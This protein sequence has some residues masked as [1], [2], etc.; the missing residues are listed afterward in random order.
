MFDGV[1]DARHRLEG[2]ASLARFGRQRLHHAAR[3]IAAGLRLRAV[4]I[5][6]IDEGIRAANTR[7]VDRHD[8]VELCGSIGVQRNRRLRRDHIFTAAH[9]DN[10]DLVAKPVHLRKFD[11]IRH[12][13]KPENCL[14]TGLHS[15][16]APRFR[17]IWRKDRQIT[18]LLRRKRGCGQ[19][20]ARRKLHRDALA[21]NG[22]RR[23]PAPSTQP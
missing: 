19:T 13:L 9:V 22:F 6:N 8:L 16:F 14:K 11:R 10:E 18:R 20:K 3:A 17:P 1:Q 2:E 21:G 7:I 15:G 23:P 4:A 12:R 5:E